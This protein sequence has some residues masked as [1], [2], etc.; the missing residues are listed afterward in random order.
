MSAASS[1]AEAKDEAICEG[2]VAALKIILAEMEGVPPQAEPERAFRLQVT[3]ELA[4][5]AAELARLGTLLLEECP[6]G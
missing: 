2:L 5:L 6:P 1:K 3:A 4:R